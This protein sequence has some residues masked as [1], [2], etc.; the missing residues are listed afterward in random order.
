MIYLLVQGLFIENIPRKYVFCGN[1][2]TFEYFLLL[3]GFT[4]SVQLDHT[5][6]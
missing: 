6:H 1:G 3:P 4:D 2:S 5:F